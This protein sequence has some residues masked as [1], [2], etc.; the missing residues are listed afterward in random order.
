MGAGR[1]G[2][3]LV[4]EGLS[5]ADLARGLAV[6]RAEKT[7]IG[8]ALVLLGLRTADEVATALARQKG[9][10]AAR[11][12]HFAAIAPGTRALVSAA[13]AKRLCAVPVG[14]VRGATPT[15]VVAMRD[16]D[17]AA[18]IA[19]LARETGHEIRPAVACEARLREVIDALGEDPPRFELLPPMID[20]LTPPPRPLPP[21]LELLELPELPASPAP[22]TIDLT[23]TTLDLPAPPLGVPAIPLSP[24][25]AP[26]KPVVVSTDL[27]LAVDPPPRAAA[28][29]TPVPARAPLGKPAALEGVSV[30]EEPA[31]AGIPRWLV[32]L[33]L[34][35][36]AAVIG[37]LAWDYFH[38]DSPAPGTPLAGEFHSKRLDAT[39]TLPGA[40]WIEQ[41]DVMSALPKMQNGSMRGDLF[42]RGDPGAPGNVLMLLRLTMDGA[43]A[44]MTPDQFQQIVDGMQSSGASLGGGV[45]A[46]RGVTCTQDTM[47]GKPLADCRGSGDIKGTTYDLRFLL[48]VASGDDVMLL[49]YLDKADA[50][51]SLDVARSIK[52]D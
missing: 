12:K 5:P 33:G 30:V 21:A 39:L 46:L 40:G 20:E 14:I 28:P 22:G 13:T 38:D 42:L 8:S 41:P 51:A 50:G 4:A 11:D 15:L 10:A 45:F 1:L 29:H 48:W 44:S 37:V 19:A 52:L 49:F 36:A 16:P 25:L 24:V 47:A 31:R 35:A 23:P 18:A 7:R 3:I 17:D 43:F 6:A 34:L 27:E 32:S 26:A 9:V 2:E